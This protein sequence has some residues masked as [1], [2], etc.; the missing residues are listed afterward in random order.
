MLDWFWK[1]KK[2]TDI[3]VGTNITV[4]DGG[5][6]SES[7]PIQAG[8]NVQITIG[9]SYEEL[10]RRI[11]AAR[12]A[13]AQ[14]VLTKAQ[15]MLREAGIQ[16]GPVSMKTVVPLLQY[17]SLEE[18]EYLR[19]KWAALLANAAV[20]GCKVRASFAEVLRQ[21][22]SQ[23]V[24]FLDALFTVT[25]ERMAG[26]LSNPPQ[27]QRGN[28]EMNL[29][30]QHELLEVFR[31]TVQITNADDVG[32]EFSMVLDNLRRSNIIDGPVLGRSQISFTAFGREFASSC[33]PPGTTIPRLTPAGEPEAKRSPE[34]V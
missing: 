14:Q 29:G 7:T 30:M 22:I 13:L 21:L 34:V 15:E 9:V 23:A 10:D 6:S 11:N 18:D 17:A 16:A 2:P 28:P 24:L 27:D 25:V 20:P 26:V 33:R 19:G 32:S 8:G 31:K 4:G 1:K 3:Q 5:K 12:G